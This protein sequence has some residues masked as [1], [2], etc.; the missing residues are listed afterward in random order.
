MKKLPQTQIQNA[1][2][3]GNI[4]FVMNTFKNTTPVPVQIVVNNATPVARQIVIDSAT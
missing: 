4:T 2:L 1:K 3:V